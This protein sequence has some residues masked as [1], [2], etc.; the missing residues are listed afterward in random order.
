MSS[1]KILTDGQGMSSL[2]QCLRMKCGGICCSNE[3]TYLSKTLSNQ[4]IYTKLALLEELEHDGIISEQ[5]KEN[6]SMRLAALVIPAEYSCC[7]CSEEQHY[8]YI[9]LRNLMKDCSNESNTKN[10]YDLIC[11][12]IDNEGSR[13]GGDNC[14]LCFTASSTWIFEVFQTVTTFF[15]T[16]GTI[17]DTDED[18]PSSKST[19]QPIQAINC[20]KEDDIIPVRVP[21]KDAHNTKKLLAKDKHMILKFSKVLNE[22]ESERMAVRLKLL[23]ELEIK[24]LPKDMCN[25]EMLPVMSQPIRKACTKFPRTANKMIIGNGL[26]VVDFETLLERTRYDLFFRARINYLITRLKTNPMI[27]DALINAKGK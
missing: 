22:I 19:R 18:D 12:C 15:N 3:F 11:T 20:R 9:Q 5:E 23:N 13:A 24:S 6:A 2:D 8:E 4:A 7:D 16:C 27:F 25:P 21:R 26:S 1:T 14:R 10:Q 17:S